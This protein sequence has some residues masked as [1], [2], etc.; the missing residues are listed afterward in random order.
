MKS[1]LSTI[2]NWF[3][4]YSP[5]QSD[6]QSVDWM[7][8]LPFIG[9]HLGCFAVLWVGFSYT[10][11]FI[12]LFLYAFR[13]FLITGIYHRYFSHKTYEM[14]R[15]WQF[16]FAALTMTAIQRGPLW[17]AAHHRDHHLQSDSVDDP[18]SPLH[19]GFLW[20]HVGWFLSGK[21]FSYKA[22]RIKD[23]LKFPELVFIDRFD[24]IV[25]VLFAG[26][27]FLIGALLN[28]YFPALNTSG[29]QIFVWGFCIST[30]CVYHVT[31]SINSFAHKVGS[32]PFKTKDSSRNNWFLA[33]LA[34]GEGWHNNHHKYPVSARQGFKWWQVDFTYY[35]LKGLNVLG[36]VHKLK[37]PP[38]QYLR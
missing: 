22:E 9:I 14:S 24:I 35:I 6:S 1:I 27:L 28:A 3:D 5:K 17:W 10:A 21:Y 26:T 29:T 11:L 18:H 33:I 31:F 8:I 7:R 4:A 32:R 19:K 34:F 12:A 38:A 15:T 23:F 16:V 13:V 20:S 2:V 37:A 36:I 30:V 25:P